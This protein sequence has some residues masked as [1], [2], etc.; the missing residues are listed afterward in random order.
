MIRQPTQRTGGRARFLNA[1]TCTYLCCIYS[2][3]I[4]VF[5]YIPI[6]CY[7]GVVVLLFDYVPKK[8]D[9]TFNT[10]HG[11]SPAPAAWAAAGCRLA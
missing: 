2:Y 11:A 5:D 7:Y 9:Y 1:V 4:L 6:F 3:Q 10:Y 8:S